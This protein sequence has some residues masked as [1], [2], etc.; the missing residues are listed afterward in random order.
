FWHVCCVGFS[1]SNNATTCTLLFH[2]YPVRDWLNSQGINAGR[3][4]SCLVPEKLSAPAV[5]CP[6]YRNAPAFE[7][8]FINGCRKITLSLLA[9]SGNAT[10]FCTVHEVG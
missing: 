9:P 6:S 10:Y 3:E 2:L 5:Q 4:N 7:G 1:G 8:L